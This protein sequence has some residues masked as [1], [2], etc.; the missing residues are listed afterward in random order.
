MRLINISIENFGKLSDFK[1]DMESNPVVILEDN[2]W[3]KSTLATFIRVMFFGFEGEGKKKLEER[4]RYRCKPWN[5]GVYGGSIEFEADS[6][7]YLIQRTFGAKAADD[8]S[9]LVDI[10]TKLPSKDYDAD[11]LGEQLFGIDSESYIRTLFIGQGNLAV[12][13][14][15]NNIEDSITAK[16][17]NLTEA[18]DDINNFA[19]VMERLSKAQNQ[20]KSGN[21]KG[22]FNLLNIERDGIIAK[23]NNAK[24]LDDEINY[25]E[26]EIKKIDEEIGG[27]KKE[28]EELEKEFII[29]GKKEAFETRKKSYEQLLKRKEETDAK[30]D[31]LKA[32]FL[33]KVPEISEIESVMNDVRAYQE[34]KNRC[35]NE[36][37][38]LEN[39]S[40]TNHYQHEKDIL[41][42]R[43]EIAI[44]EWK[45]EK[46][47]LLDAYKDNCE[48]T[49]ASVTANMNMTIVSGIVIA[50]VLGL[51]ALVVNVMAGKA[52][53]A[54]TALCIAGVVA[55]LVIMAVAVWMKPKMIENKV[56][57]IEKPVMPAEPDFS[58]DE[59]RLEKLRLEEQDKGGQNENYL[60]SVKNMNSMK[61]KILEWFSV[62]GITNSN[63]W[64]RDLYT[65]KQK[66]ESL[67]DYIT[68]QKD[69]ENELAEFGDEI[70]EESASYEQVRDSKEIMRRRDEL[71][72]ICDALRDRA[73]QIKKACDEKYDIK[74]EV[75]D[76]RS[77]L[78]S[79]DEKLEELGHKYDIIKSTA[80]YLARA[81]DLLSS[82]YMDP[83][84][85]AF[86]RYYS[87]I[88]TEYLDGYELDAEINVTRQEM[89][90]KRAQYSLSKGYQD[91]VDV[92]L[93]MSLVDVMYK[94][95]KP[96]IILDDPFVNLDTDKLTQVKE[97]I[98]EIAKEYQVI[99]FTCH[100]SRA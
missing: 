57:Q 31:A 48:S 82:R 4:E 54:V 49:K 75:E 84:N 67:N 47:N 19:N 90:H 97:F 1:L 32:Y 65:A 15:K 89:G 39:V 43:K 85:D 60:L 91:L 21:K 62:Y 40:Q 86:V 96:W 10:T 36:K 13:N 78:D 25:F 53:I 81:K 9:K 50:V 24:Y 30:V 23:I 46:A 35:E 69:I 8:E 6:K 77:R 63:D 2:G 27:H 79:I 95:E 37:V 12:R 68:K 100:E 28:M 71:D 94:G 73:T 74:A 55:G 33:D 80:D 99:Y 59:E 58:L 38:K 44:N 52:A 64:L 16:I 11:T 45:H 76:Q 87:Y 83:I 70:K 51:V 98:E 72:D 92:A 20:I 56:S 93:R 66:V 88:T 17:G 26:N 22:E 3:G 14:D 42:M 61:E 34:L 41:Q 7:R 29:S 18:T 5:N